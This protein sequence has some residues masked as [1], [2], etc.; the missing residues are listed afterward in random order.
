VSRAALVLA[1]AVFAAGC[2]GST[3]HAAACP[4]A[5]KKGWQQLANR[6]RTPVYCPTW[7]PAP[8]TGDTTGP[9][10]NGVSVKK[11]GSYLVSFIAVLPPQ[12]VHF[13]FRGYPGQTSVPKC[14]EGQA[15]IPCFSRP[16]GHRHANGIDATVYLTGQDAD[17][18]H[19]VYAWTDHGTF[20]EISELVNPPYSRKQV[21]HNLDG[22]LKGLAL[23]QPA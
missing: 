8:L 22:A 23:V 20:Y 10:R 4:S 6:I 18:N 3:H 5:W 17:A 13:N 2:G 11:D 12:V 9:Y 1:A 15:K 16:A 19:I 21:L 7:L 14:I